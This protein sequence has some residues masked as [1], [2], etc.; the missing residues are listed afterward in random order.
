MC[1]VRGLAAALLHSQHTWESSGTR[2]PIFD[3]QGAEVLGRLGD[4]V[5]EEGHDDAPRG[6]A[7]DG[8]VEENLGAGGHFERIEGEM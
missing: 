7:T 2:P 5:R 6:L 1:A 3:S 4:D 8:D